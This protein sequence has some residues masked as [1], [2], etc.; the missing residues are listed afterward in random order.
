M[1]G[2]QNDVPGGMQ[3]YLNGLTSTTLERESDSGVYSSQPQAF[4]G[5]EI[6]GR[7]TI[8]TRFS[9]A[10][11][12]SAGFLPDLYAMINRAYGG[13]H[14]AQL[15]KLVKRDR[16]RYDNQFLDELGNKPTF[17]FV[18]SFDHCRSRVNVR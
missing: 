10:Q 11:I 4:D 2:D 1:N 15:V 16:L 3:A 7:A 14:E 5:P 9:R 8:V 17:T 13:G 6:N 18:G 12:T